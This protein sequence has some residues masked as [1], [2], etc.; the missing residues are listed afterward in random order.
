VYPGDGLERSCEIQR[1]LESYSGEAAAARYNVLDR[2]PKTVDFAPSQASV[3]DPILFN[4]LRGHS[5]GGFLSLCG[6][7]QFLRLARLSGS[8]SSLLGGSVVQSRRFRDRYKSR[9]RSLQ[10]VSTLFWG[11]IVQRRSFLQCLAGFA[12]ATAVP[13]QLLASVFP[14][15]LVIVGGGILGASLAYYLARRGARVTLL[16]KDAPASGATGRSFAWINADFSKQPLHYHQLNRL[17]LMSYRILEQQ[18]PGLPV[19]WGGCLQW[20]LDAPRADGLRRQVRQQQ[21]WGYN[22]RLVGEQEFHDLESQFQPGK[23]QVASFAEQEG[24][25]DPVATT[26]LLLKGAQAAGAEIIHPCEVIGFDL[27]SGR[28]RTVKTTLGPFPADFLILAA[29]V[30]TPSL[31]SL[32]DVHIPL[33]PAPGLLVH[34]KPMPQLLHRVVVGPDAHLKQYHDG[35]MVIGDDFGPPKTSVHEYLNRHPLDF[36]TEAIRALHQQRIL[37]QASQYLPQ[38]ADAPVEKVTLG[39]RPMPKDGFPI[40]GATSRCP[41]LYVVVTHSGVTLAPILG[42]IVSL[43]VLDRVEVLML[44]PYRP[45]RFL[46][47]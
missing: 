35:R 5:R 36:P 37:K 47:S 7:K 25:I 33:V 19:Q 8:S 32:A 40:V 18:L 42:E 3:I 10:H 15:R 12:G 39:W 28:V 17:S 34:A 20:Y 43:E 45:S 41:N 46:S 23:F 26:A 13:S 21:E 14:E 9:C 22:V 30:D 24:F 31:A 6:E 44:E 16:E 2:V 38:V 29:G 4:E 27:E 11:A 1:C